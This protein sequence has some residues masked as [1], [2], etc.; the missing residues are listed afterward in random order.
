MYFKFACIEHKMVIILEQLNYERLT[1]LKHILCLKDIYADCKNIHRSL[2]EPHLWYVLYRS[3]L[4]GY[5]PLFRL[6]TGTC[7]WVVNYD[8]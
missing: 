2:K 6:T 3:L 7:A 8:K 1:T 5:F 4:L